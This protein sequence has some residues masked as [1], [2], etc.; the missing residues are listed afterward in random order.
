[1]IMK[2]CE[3]EKLSSMTQ[4]ER[5][6]AYI[7]EHGS[8][9]QIEALRE[10]GVMR[11]ASRVSDLRKQGYRITGK[12]VPVKNRWQEVCHVKQYSEVTQDG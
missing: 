10:L 12:T 1:M 6:L 8:I 3:A 11:L 9:T 2:P 7:R 4:D 5:V